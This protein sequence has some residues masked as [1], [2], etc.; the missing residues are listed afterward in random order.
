MQNQHKYCVFLTFFELLGKIGNP[1]YN[2]ILHQNAV[3]A[4][5]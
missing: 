4:L 5:F 3:L 1:I 2:L